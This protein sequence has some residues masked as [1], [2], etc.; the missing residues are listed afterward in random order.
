MIKDL[1]NFIKDKMKN[2][3]IFD[4]GSKDCQQS[5]EFYKILPHAQI[6][7]FNCDPN[8]IDSC[9]SNI[10][11]YRDRITLIQN[12]DSIHFDIDLCY[13]NHH[14]YVFIQ[15]IIPMNKVKLVANDNHVLFEN[16][17]NVE[18]FCVYHKQFYI[19][20]D[21]FYFTFFGVNEVYP[22]EGGCNTILEYELNKYNPF[23]QKRG[24]M[25]TSVYLHVY[26]NKLY[27]K[28]DMVGFSQYDMKHNQMYDKIDKNTI[29]LLNTDTYIVSDGK[30]NSLMFPKLR[31]LDFLL[32]S[33]NNH[34]KKT[35]S[36]EDLERKPL[37]LWQTNI[38]PIKIFEKLCGWL[39]HVVDEIYPWSNQP[40]Y[41]THFGSIGG[42]TERAISIFN[43]F[44]I[45][46]GVAHSNLHITHGLGA[47]EKEQY[48]NNSFLNRYS[49]DVHTKYIENV[50]GK[51]ESQFCMFK[52]E[53]HLDNIKYSCERVNRQINGLNFIRSDWMNTRENAFDIEGEDPRMIIVNNQVYV[54]FICL[55]PYIGQ[56]RCIGITPFNTWEPKFLQI[57]NMKH[58]FIEKNWAPFV[59]DETLHFVYNYDP[60]IIIKYDFNVK[61][62]CNIVYKQDEVSLP[63]D[64]SKTFLRGGSNLIHYN[65][66]Y[67]VGG[68]H[69]RIYKGCYQHYTH[70]ILLDILNWR[71]V[72]L[73]KPIM[74]YYNLNEKLNAW[75]VKSCPM[76]KE[77]GRLH[78][79]L[80]DRAPN[81]IQ[82]PI[83]LFVKDGKYF[84][85]VNVRDCIS[86][87]YEMQFENL[88]QYKESDGKDIGYWDDKTK[89]YSECV[90]N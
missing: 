28:R 9:E 14:D 67:Y 7:V 50:T 24:Y 10:K 42:Y 70:M 8:T 20:K 77:I 16:Y 23:L 44:E 25:E 2:Y 66:N 12:M 74:Y 13:I 19:R 39:E 11:P 32:E 88:L 26:W 1:S 72:Y 29:Y 83:S 81:I 79:I 40:P 60:L 82:D 63:I 85:T 90:N 21:N 86:L 52:A 78:N 75:H 84:L 27:V 6:Y 49:Q 35:Y 22:K 53:C 64:T 38:Y 17:S 18:M 87:L 54:I 68:C 61:G 73:S 47:V 33:Y 30:W 55:S 3:V 36:M 51:H 43:A 31:N 4:V 71:I 76:I 80:N 57:E 65:E 59:K 45:F 41:E 37:S 89:A 46:E 62:I 48:N 34:F 15:N 5:I 69:S 56:K 58:T